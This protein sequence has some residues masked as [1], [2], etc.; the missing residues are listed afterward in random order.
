MPEPMTEFKL[1]ERV[2]YVSKTGDYEMPATVSAT[3]RSLHRPN[4]EAGHIPDLSDAACVHLT[5]DTAGWPGEISASTLA[6]QPEYARPNRPGAPA[7][8][9]LQ[10]WNIPYSAGAL[11]GTFHRGVEC[12]KGL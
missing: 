11:R 4:V 12:P 10:E 6:N 9:T 2:H 1:G 8:G 3:G 5:V 7:G